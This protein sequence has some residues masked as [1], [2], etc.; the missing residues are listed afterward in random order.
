MRK[1]LIT[2]LLCML[3]SP[4]LALTMSSATVDAWQTVAAGTMNE[5]NI[6]DISTSASTYIAIQ[7]TGEAGQDLLAGDLVFA[8]EIAESDV[9]PW[10]LYR[11]IFAIGLTTL[12]DTISGTE[13]AGQEVVTLTD[14]STDGFDT[15][16]LKWFILDGTIANSEVVRT[17]SASSNN[18]TLVDVT[19]NEHTNSVVINEVHEIIVSI[20]VGF[21]KVRISPINA[22]ATCDAYYTVIL[23]ETAL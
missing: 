19:L 16:G 17:K 14:A 12:G 6:T 7:Y 20:P 8:V 15:I 2:L 1:L 13:A 18:L 3:V 11:N 23:A 9:G 10:I 22:D 4:V 5:G 21:K